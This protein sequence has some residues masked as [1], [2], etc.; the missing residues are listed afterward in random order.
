MKLLTPLI[1]LVEERCSVQPQQEQHLFPSF[2]A[3]NT[4]DGCT[5]RILQ[6]PRW[7]IVPCHNGEIRTE[8][9]DVRVWDPSVGFQILECEDCRSLLECEVPELVVR[10][11][12]LA[13]FCKRNLRHSTLGQP[14]FVRRSVGDL[15]P[16]FTAECC[17]DERLLV[18]VHRSTATGG[19]TTTTP[20]SEP[21]GR[22]IKPAE[23]APGQPTCVRKF[24]DGGTPGTV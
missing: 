7:I 23:P 11:G 14:T 3:D 22:M 5:S 9:A 15:R 16:T 1:H 18:L 8:S 10:N 6:H 2:L 13:E 19:I 24:A 17:F 21:L 12:P 4:V 20:N